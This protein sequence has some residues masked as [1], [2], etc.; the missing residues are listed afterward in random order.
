[1]VFSG[2]RAGLGERGSRC[3]AVGIGLALGGRAIAS[4]LAMAIR[5]KLTAINGEFYRDRQ[6][7]R[8]RQDIL[9]R[10]FWDD[11]RVSNRHG[12]LDGNTLSVIEMR[13]RRYF[14]IC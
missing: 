4:I 10:V 9:S 11:R 8:D 5:L 6:D 12:R 14:W 7:E 2:M 3:L 13:S 1:M